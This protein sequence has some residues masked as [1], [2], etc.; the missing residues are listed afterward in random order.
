MN[1]N[2][3]GERL[4]RIRQLAGVS[5]QEIEKKYNIS[6]NTIKSWECGINETGIVK[7]VHY[8]KIF[9]THYNIPIDMNSFLDLNTDNYFDKTMLNGEYLPSCYSSDN[10][11]FLE[12]K[13]RADLKLIANTVTN[14]IGLVH[15]EKE[16][17][18]R[19]IINALP[20][21][22]VF[23]DD[24][25]NFIYV[26]RPAAET[27]GGSIA[28]FENKNNYDLFPQFAKKYHEE[29]LTVLQSGQSKNII[30]QINPVNLEPRHVITYKA[31]LITSDNKRL[32]LAVFKDYESEIV[33]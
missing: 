26:N 32:V 5:R 19:S 33:F 29:D 4:Y 12:N 17:M 23:K 10:S 9:E 8:L 22:I 6:A 24:N 25:N 16:E 30:E 20:Y 21:K 2:I 11:Y 28:D 18:L 14:L 1:I 7:L 3:L 31:P 13:N 27:F 15:N